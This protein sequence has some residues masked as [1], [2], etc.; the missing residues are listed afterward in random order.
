LSPQH[1][2]RELDG[3]GAAAA[4]VFAAVAA[5]VTAAP[6]GAVEL[7]DPQPLCLRIQRG[8][9]LE[10]SA[11]Q[12]GQPTQSRWSTRVLN[13][14]SRN[15]FCRSAAASA[16]PPLWMYSHALNA[17]IAAAGC[18]AL[19]SALQRAAGS[20]A[21][22]RGTS[23]P[24]SEGLRGCGVGT[25]GGTYVSGA[26]SVSVSGSAI[27]RSSMVEPFTSLCFKGGKV[28]PQSILISTTLL[29][30]AASI[31]L[32]FLCPKPRTRLRRPSLL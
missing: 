28:L 23:N 21:A 9:S 14:L 17:G 4:E 6:V 13:S 32:S 5:P 31:T 8:S 27:S 26:G 1:A 20:V 29:E 24:S 10:P 30:W 15:A 25:A 19:L 22:L 7:H 11:P 3:E 2:A 18:R 12:P 16:P